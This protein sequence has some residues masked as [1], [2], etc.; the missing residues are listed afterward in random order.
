MPGGFSVTYF[1]DYKALE[2]SEAM[3]T[4]ADLRAEIA[5]R[6]GNQKANLPWLKLATFGDKRTEKNSLRHDANVQA[7]S[8][9]EADYDGEEVPFE[10]AVAT[11]IEAGVAGI[12]Y[13]SPS[14]STDKPRWRVLCPLSAPCAPVARAQH[15]DRLNGVF[16]GIFADESWTLSQSYYYGSVQNNPAHAAEVIDGDPIDLR[17]DLDRT[18]IGKPSAETPKPGKERDGPVNETVLL[19][20]ICRGQ[21]YH[22]NIV[23]LLGKWAGEGVP[24]V[25]ARSR[26]TA[27]ME[28]VQPS[29]RDSRWQARFDDI[30]RSLQDIYGKQAGKHDAVERGAKAVPA[31][32]CITAHE[33]V[34]T[35]FPPRGM[36][37]APWFPEKGLAMIYGPRGIGKT[38]LTLGVGY[39]IA[40]GGSFLR[41]GA[42]MPRRVVILDGEM[43]AVALR[44]RVIEI[45]NREPLEPPDPSYLRFLA[46][47]LQERGLDLSDEAHQR[48]LERHLE[49]ADVII[50]DNISTLCQGGR[51]N[52]AESWLPVQQWA[53]IQRRAGRSVLFMHHAGKGGAQRGTSRR[54]DV[55]D[56]V[57]ALR[58][59]DDYD[60]AEGARFALHFEKSRGF[61]GDEAKPFEARLTP[62]G[63]TTR[64]LADAD[65]ARVV[66]LHADGMT[67]REIAAE[68]GAGWS[69]SK[70]NRLQ[71]KARE[72]GLMETGGRA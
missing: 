20:E 70:V 23:K 55:L 63:W 64:D 18:A 30:D 49:G 69:K 11:M 48:E 53:L 34:S 51:E 37:L 67:T 58:R 39:A 59:P 7:V 68:L 72:L 40:S 24:Y 8:G 46:M 42:R 62:T 26:I 71:A 45:A 4:L 56:T 33:L 9:I 21:S 57:I 16:G 47:D 54:E 66:A 27:A 22:R 36:V 1:K 10:K 43:P 15:M 35:D 60:P 44:E 17:D 19:A 14:H 28:G 41:W 29:G 5:A 12:V 61:H 13:T 6:T 65:M 52:E 3:R 38:H 25:E 50:A 32:T 2:K 31:L